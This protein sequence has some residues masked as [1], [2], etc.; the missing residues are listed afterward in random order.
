MTT[1]TSTT[2][3]TSSSDSSSTTDPNTSS[4]SSGSDSSSTGD[5]SSSSGSESSTGSGSS[6]TGEAACGPEGA[7]IYQGDGCNFCDCEGGELTNCTTRTCESIGGCEYDGTMYEYAEH[8]DSTDGCNECVCAASGLACTRRD[9]CVDGNE[10]GA[11]LLEDDDQLCGG[12]E[13][14]NGASVKSG[15]EP[16]SRTGVLDYNELGPLYPDTLPDTDMTLSITFPEDGFVVCR[17][18]SAGQEALD[19]EAVLEWRSDDGQFDEAQHTYVR[20]NFRGFLMAYTGVA[21]IDAQNIHGTY[22]PGC[23]DAQSISIGP[24]WNDDGTAQT[25]ISKTCETDIGLQT[26]EW[27]S[28][29]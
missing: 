6:S 15:L 28:S 5:A 22:S 16:L 14:F 12:L 19:I 29:P 26:G 13:G 10:E 11:I 8:F 21:S 24:R 20:R 2:A 9:K 17:I 23:P 7:R 25:G 1:T 4:S 3:D 27:T 18:P